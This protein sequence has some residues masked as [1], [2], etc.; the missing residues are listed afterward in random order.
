MVLAAMIPSLEK[1]H[2]EDQDS[3]LFQQNIKSFVKVLE[4]N[5]LLDGRLIEGVEFTVAALTVV[6]DH[7]LDRK[8]RGWMITD[9]TALAGTG[10]V[11]DDW[12]DKTLTL[13]ASAACDL[14]L[15]V[16]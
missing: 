1:Q 2:T 12:T 16:F 6:V 7:K 13:T 8:P 5:P 15:W 3:E 11:R 9:F 10:V 14:D 4:D